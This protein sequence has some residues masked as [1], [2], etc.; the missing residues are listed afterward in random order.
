MSAA[1]RQSQ[2]GFTLIEVIVAFAVLAMA[3][4]LL[5]G[6]LSRGLG[7]VKQAGNETEATLH[8]QSLLDT[9]GT[10][11]PIAPGATDGDFEDGRYRW[12]L[13]VAETR[14]PAPPPPP[15]PGEPLPPAQPPTGLAVPVLYRVALDVQW[16]AA[17]PR[18]RLH[19]ETLRLRAPPQ[20]EGADAAGAVA[21]EAG[22]AP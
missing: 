8:A 15:A 7:Q 18:Q 22:G 5:L 17:G 2:R 4:G 16:G 10:L 21:A 9:L 13:Q 20:G 14:D 11:G 3:L 19:F 12:R 6:M 1:R